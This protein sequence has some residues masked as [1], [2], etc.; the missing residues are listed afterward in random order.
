MNKAIVTGLLLGLLVVVPVEAPVQA[1]EGP[2][3]RVPAVQESN[4]DP[5]VQEMFAS[6]KARGGQ[7][8]N[9]SLIRANAPKLAKPGSGVAYAIR[10]DTKTPR[11][12]IELAILRTAELYDGV[13][14]INQHRPMM[15]AC[16]YTPEQIDAVAHWQDSS[17]F[18][19][20]Q[21]ALLAYVDQAARGDVD[22]PTFAAFATFFD[23][24]EIVEITITVDNYVGTALF[25]RALRIQ[26][27]TDGRETSIGKC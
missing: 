8:I 14:E 17:L 9:L 24:Q 3:A 19:E 22:D 21:R 15:R 16:N 23:T 12:L 25:T 27:E 5:I 20:K 6:A 10:Y 4:P 7:I 26:V 2:I 13:Y 18:D 11:R 1:E